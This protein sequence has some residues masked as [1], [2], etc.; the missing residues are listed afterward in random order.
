MGAEIPILILLV[1]T[2]IALVIVIVVK[3]KKEADKKKSSSVAGGSGSTLGTG[4]PGSAPG[5]GPEAAPPPDPSESFLNTLMRGIGSLV[6]QVAISEAVLRGIKAV[7]PDSWKTF[8]KNRLKGHQGFKDSIRGPRAERINAR[9]GKSALRSR[10]ANLSPSKL[11]GLGGWWPKEAA[12]RGW[13]ADSIKAAEAAEKGVAREAVETAAEEGAA[14]LAA[15]GAAGAELGPIDAAFLV[16][17]A[18]SMALDFANVGGLMDIQSQKTSDFLAEKKKNDDSMT[19]YASQNGITLPM[20]VGPLDKYSQDDLDAAIEEAQFEILGSN[21]N[22]HPAVQAI[23]TDLYNK[24]QQ[25]GGTVTT[26]L[27]DASIIS[28]LTDQQRKDLADAALEKVCGSENGTIVSGA[29]SYP[30]R[31]A[32]LGSYTWPLPTGSAATDQDYAEWRPALNAC[33]RA[34]YTIHQLCDNT[35]KENGITHQIGRNEYR[36]DTGECVNTQA[37][38]D[39]YGYAFDPQRPQAMM[40]NLGS[41]PLPCCFQDSSQYLCSQVLGNT[42]CQGSSMLA[43]AV[44]NEVITPGLNAVGCAF[45][46]CN[47]G[48]QEAHVAQQAQQAVDQGL[49]T[50]MNTVQQGVNYDVNVVGQGFQDLGNSVTNTAHDAGCSVM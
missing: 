27:F 36:S 1:L 40:G 5:P 21:T 47:L 14:R 32:C 2:I 35:T 4:G 23:I 31:D 50:A 15:E 37:F 22:P 42:I 43:T 25:N 6:T 33:V 46:D 10:F 44:Q 11:R 18:A 48:N 8:G 9:V 49:G 38:C 7:A 45:G 26:A 41:G 3:K 12:E 34:D 39:A 24:A 13:T 16:V 29:C 20:I 17:S 28:S 19:Q 30:T